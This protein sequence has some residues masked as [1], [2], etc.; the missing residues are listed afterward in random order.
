ERP[1]WLRIAHDKL[2]RAVLAAYAAIDPKGDW[3]PDWAEV[4]EPFGAGS[5]TIKREGRGADNVEA[6]GKKEAAIEA[7]EPIDQRILAS[8]LHLNGL[9]GEG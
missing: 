7:R 3:D 9:R 8:L 5:I 1:A 6:I 4:Y 2:D